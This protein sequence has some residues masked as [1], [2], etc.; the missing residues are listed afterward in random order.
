MTFKL[1]VINSALIA[2]GLDP[3]ASEFDGSTEWTIANE[4]FERAVPL[5]LARHNWQ[6]ATRN[7]ALSRIGAS[8]IAE[9]TDQ[10]QRPADALQILSVGDLD[11]GTA[12]PWTG[13]DNTILVNQS[14]ARIHYVRAPDLGAW[15]V[16]FKESV[17]LKIQAAIYRSEDE[18]DAARAAERDFEHLFTVY[19]SRIDQE[20]PKRALLKSSLRESRTV[21]R[22]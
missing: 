8:P 15:P 12:L 10:F 6:F 21:R 4:A 19:T 17:L 13:L 9:W 16:L 1:E 5:V 14:T 7:V 22:G 18:F 11:T 3:V 2:T 20:R